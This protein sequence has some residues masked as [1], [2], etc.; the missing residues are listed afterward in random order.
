MTTS[1]AL[2]DAMESIKTNGKM[3]YTAPS[4]L[5]L[6][7]AAGD[8]AGTAIAS[9]LPDDAGTLFTHHTW[10]AF[11]AV[12]GPFQVS[13]D[14]SLHTCP[15]SNIDLSPEPVAYTASRTPT[16]VLTESPFILDTGATCHISCHRC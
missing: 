12:N 2:T 16:E 1:C 7:P 11:T 3:Y 8:F 4:A 5:A 13:L 6:L 14:W 9:P 15:L 10:K